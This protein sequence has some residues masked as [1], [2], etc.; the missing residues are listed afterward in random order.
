MVK[1]GIDLNNMFSIHRDALLRVQI[2][3]RNVL[4]QSEEE[5]LPE[6]KMIKSNL[7]AAQI[8]LD[9]LIKRLEL[10]EQLRP[11]RIL[12]ANTNNEFMSKLLI[13]IASLIGTLV[14]Y[15]TK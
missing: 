15:L 1:S 3:I 6:F 14:K 9:T 12:G 5:Q 8:T 11:I 13:G 7:Q 10:D 2:E 4:T